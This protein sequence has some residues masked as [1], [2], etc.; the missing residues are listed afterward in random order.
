MTATGN[1]L[2]ESRFRTPR[3]TPYTLVN[4]PTIEYSA[5]GPLYST[6]AYRILRTDCTAFLRELTPSPYKRKGVVYQ[7]EF[8]SLNVPRLLK[9]EKVSV[10]GLLANDDKPLDPFVTDSP[11]GGRL[12]PNFGSQHQTV[13]PNQSSK[14]YDDQLLVTVEYGTSLASRFGMKQSDMPESILERSFGVS[15]E[16]L[17]LNPNRFF[18][19]SDS[20]AAQTTEGDDGEEASTA[21]PGEAITDMRAPIAKLSSIIEH[22][23]RWRWAIDPD[24]STIMGLLGTVNAERYTWLNNAPIETVMF[25]GLTG[26]QDFRAAEFGL[27][28][29]IAPWDLTYKLAER[30]AVDE[31]SRYTWNHFFN[32]SSDPPRWMRLQRGTEKRPLYDLTVWR[33][34]MFKCT[35]DP[36]DEPPEE[37]EE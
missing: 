22:T 1:T 17:S 35:P 30:L 14:T 12:P 19:A 6:A 27:A 20:S 25:T 36:E 26:T 33:T 21:D 23:L 32:P 28:T 13:S 34:D 29:L 15:A 5:H 3:G 8:L 4:G 2:S 16:L 11:D 37:D 31:S 9:P 24:F 7:P 18:R 10:A